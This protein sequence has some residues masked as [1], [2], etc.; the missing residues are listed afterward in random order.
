MMSFLGS[1]LYNGNNRITALR[2]DPCRMSFLGRV[3]DNENNRITALRQDSVLHE[4]P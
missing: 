2:Q 1:V 3:L 4:F